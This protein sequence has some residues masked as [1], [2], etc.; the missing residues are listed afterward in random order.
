MHNVQERFAAAVVK[1]D[2]GASWPC[3]RGLEKFLAL[4]GTSMSTM[5]L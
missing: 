4:F 2:I 3:A 5:E 1:D